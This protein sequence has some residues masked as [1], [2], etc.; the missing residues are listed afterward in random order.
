MALLPIWSKIQRHHSKD[1]IE[2]M[3]IVIYRTKKDQFLAALLDPVDWVRSMSPDT[4]HAAD[5]DNVC[6]NV[7]I[8]P[9]FDAAGR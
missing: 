8:G 1:L 6:D 9:L 4:E 2:L 3:K 5:N 7:I